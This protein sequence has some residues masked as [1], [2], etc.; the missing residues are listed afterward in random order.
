MK[1]QHTV[2]AFSKFVFAGFFVIERLVNVCQS[3]QVFDA[4]LYLFKMLMACLICLVT[5]GKRQIYPIPFLYALNAQLNLTYRLLYTK[6]FNTRKKP[7]KRITTDKLNNWKRTHMKNLESH[8]INN[9]HKAI[10]TKDWK[11]W[12]EKKTLILK[13]NNFVSISV[14]CF[15]P[16]YTLPLHDTKQRKTN[17][18]VHGTRANIS[19]SHIFMH[20]A[21][22]IIYEWTIFSDIYASRSPNCRNF[23]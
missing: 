3:I 22:Y 12:R 19:S 1:I 8:Y 16:R 14:V 10:T 20:H 23:M 5:V 11:T 21:S 7:N 2:T 13:L 6:L 18:T 17:Y 4:W 15:E 9:Q